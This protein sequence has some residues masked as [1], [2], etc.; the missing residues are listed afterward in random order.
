MKRSNVLIAIAVASALLVAGVVVI[1]PGKG[2]DVL[3]GNDDEAEPPVVPGNLTDPI[4]T[5][6]HPI[7]IDEGDAKLHLELSYPGQ[8][9]GSR[10]EWNKE[11]EIV[12]RTSGSG[13]TGRTVIKVFAERTEGIGSK[14]LILSYGNDVAKWES[15]L[16]HGIIHLSTDTFVWI[17][18]GQD[19]RTDSFNV[20]FNRTGTFVLTFQAFDA[21]SGA[22][23]SA[24]VSTDEMIVPEEGRVAVKA[25]GAEW[26]TIGN[27]SYLVVLINMTNEWNVR[28][29]V[30]ITH[31]GL[32]YD[33]GTSKVSESLTSFKEQELEPGVSTQFLAYFPLDEGAEDVELIY[34]EPGQPPAS[35]P[36]DL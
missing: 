14:C 16:V 22:P 32:S 24:P 23:L 13:W 2:E 30:N 21:D 28:H 11:Y 19:E 10:F 6:P 26:K 20:L 4:A 33:Q 31:L 3:P 27:A 36:L 29:S 8:G 18:D 34:A 9:D 17:S 12:L 25:L 7:E 1:S 35:V 15:H 5:V